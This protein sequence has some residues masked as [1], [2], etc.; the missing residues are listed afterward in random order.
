MGADGPWE[1]GPMENRIG[2]GLLDC[3]SYSFLLTKKRK[4]KI[5]RRKKIEREGMDGIWAWK[6]NSR[7]HN[8]DLDP[9]KI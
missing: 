4:I 9:R 2:Q 7:T 8:N 5:D 1:A 3:L 6:L